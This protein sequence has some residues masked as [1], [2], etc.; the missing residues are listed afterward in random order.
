VPLFCV[1]VNVGH[2][3][4]TGLLIRSSLSLEGKVWFSERGYEVQW[5]SDVK[6]NDSG[7]EVRV[8]A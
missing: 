4:F 2:G 3:R 1:V 6:E 5:E 7:R 8:H